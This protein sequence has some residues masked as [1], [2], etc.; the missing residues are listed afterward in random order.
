MVSQ[1]PSAVGS[2]KGSI[3]KEKRDHSSSGQLKD[4]EVVEVTNAD[5]ALALASGPKLSPTSASSIQLFLILLVAFMGSMSNGFDGQAGFIQ[6]VMGAVNGMQQYL[7]FF[8]IPADEGGG[9][10]TPT[11]LIF[12]IYNVG[13]IVGVLVAGP[14]T[15]GYFG[16]R[17]G[18]FTGALIIIVGAIAITLAQSRSYLL[19]GR[20]VLGF[21]VSIAATACPSYVVELSPPQWRGRLT[22]LYNICAAFYYAGSIL[23][24]GVSIG[25]GRLSST[26]SWRA[27]L[28]I[29]LVPAGILVL[30]VWFL[31]E[32]PRWLMSV[33]QKEEARKVLA[34]YHGNGDENAPLVQLQWKE[35]EEAIRL[36]ASDKRWY[37]YS[38]LF[39]TANARYR[40]YMMLMMGFF[41][42][43][44]GNGLGYF[45][46]VLFG[47][48][49]VRSQERRLVLNFVNTI[50]SA[51]GAS[52]GTSLSDT[53]GRRKMWF[54]G[55]LASASTLVIVTGCTARFGLEG[56]NNQ[57]GANAAIAFIFLFGFVF[58][59][60]YTPLQ[61]LYPTE[62]LAY[63]TRA[64]GMALYSLAVSCAGLVGQY[65]GPIALQR[66]TWRYYIVYICWDL[67]ECAMVWFFAVETKGRTLEELD[68]IFQSPNPVKASLAKHKV[69]I[70][71]K[72]D[73]VEMVQVDQLN[74]N[75]SPT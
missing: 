53:V 42:Q 39:N 61:A 60:A 32:S 12:G 41:G 71:K 36:D 59:L 24:T 55:T 3:E 13:S 74:Q 5:Y 33:N 43:W 58:S 54:W 75:G 27:P 9:V 63:N 45:L 29:Q 67:F 73:H 6:H 31:P 8:G 17:G 44:S 22:G 46:T 72:S 66:I 64:K 52:I 21:G 26:T 14:L 65:A 49:G 38:E 23:C 47:N 4:A 1:E 11:A 7:N 62:C 48:A 20:F 10:G 19:G 2:D 25:T 30:F 34:K 40:T 16:R 15:D 37:D 69:A 50:I 28:A 57:A 56:S 51:I 68:E 35:F 18:M 70:V